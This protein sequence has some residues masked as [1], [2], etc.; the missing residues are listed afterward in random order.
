MPM[1]FLN[2]FKRSEILKQKQNKYMTV[3]IGLII[4]FIPSIVAFNKKKKNASK[5]LVLNFFLGWT[6]IG[7]VIALIMAVG[8]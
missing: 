3:I 7:W 5:V 4:Y 1:S 6:F 2:L 8:E